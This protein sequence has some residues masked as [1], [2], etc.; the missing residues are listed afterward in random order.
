MSKN[1][2]WEVSFFKVTL[3]KYCYWV[4]NYIILCGGNI[5]IDHYIYIYCPKISQGYLMNP[6]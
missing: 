5:I 6:T 1:L 3:K 4:Y 2:K